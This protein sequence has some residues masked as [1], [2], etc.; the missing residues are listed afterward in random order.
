[1]AI[2]DRSEALARKRFRMVIRAKA[3][4]KV[5]NK[6]GKAG[7]DGENAARGSETTALAVVD[8]QAGTGSGKAAVAASAEGASSSVAGAGVPGLPAAQQNVLELLLDGKSFAEAA[9]FSGVC[10]AT[11]YNWMKRDPAFMAAYNTWH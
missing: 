5:L 2:G 10:R 7:E 6:K 3:A 8:G 1:M 4:G 9:R 11:I